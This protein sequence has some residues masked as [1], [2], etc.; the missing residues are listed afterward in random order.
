MKKVMKAIMVPDFGTAETALVLDSSVKRPR[1]GRGEV[2]VRQFATSINIIDI[3]RRAGYGKKVFALRFGARPPM[4]LGEDISGE[5]VSTGPGVS[6]FRKGDRVFGVKP[7]SRNGTYAE[8]VAVRAEHIRPAPAHMTPA[9]LAAIPYAFMTAWTAL[10][11]KCGLGPKTPGKKVFVQGGAG[12]VG[13]AA[14]QIAKH[15]G[16]YV[17]VSCSERDEAFAHEIGADIVFDRRKDDYTSRLSDFDVALCSADPAEEKKM[18]SILRRDGGATFATIIHPTL[19]LTEQYG[20]LRGLWKARQ[21]RRAA[22]RSPEGKG[23]RIEWVFF[24]ASKHGL[25]AMAE[26]A[27]AGKLK[28][29]Q[30]ARSFPL[31]QATDAHLAVEAGS[32]GKVL[33]EMAKP[34]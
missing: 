31:V 29:P 11:D 22:M 32:H 14:V 25:D 21:E 33:L 12:A 30:I 23:R 26:M 28:A 18:L 10:V 4:I 17:A 15:F 3:A 27:A 16:A 5:V 24:E 34:N 1:S 2:L 7:P 8:Y 9:E 20:L 13:S 19:T 6:G